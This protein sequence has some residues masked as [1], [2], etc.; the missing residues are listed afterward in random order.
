MN[1]YVIEEIS[2]IPFSCMKFEL[3]FC[4]IG[5][6]ARSLSLSSQEKK[7][8]SNL[9]DSQHTSEFYERKIKKFLVSSQKP[10]RLRELRREKLS[11][12]VPHLSIRDDGQDDKRV[13]HEPFGHA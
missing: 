2:A 7:K 10:K 5:I 12:V 9:V 3:L 4:L 1:T 11:V 6:F 13:S 8:S